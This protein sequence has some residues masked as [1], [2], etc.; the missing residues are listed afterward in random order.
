MK[1]RMTVIAVM[2][3][4]ISLSWTWPCFAAEKT[5]NLVFTVKDMVNP[6]WKGG[7]IG[8]QKAV[9][10]YK[11]VNITY[12]TPTKP[13]NIAEQTSQMEDII[14]RRPDAIVFVPVD[15]VAL[16]PTVEKMNKAGIPVFNYCNEVVGAKKQLY[17]GVDDEKLAY[18][19]AKFA[20]NAIGNKGKVVIID[21][22]PGAI[23][24]QNR[25]TGFMKAV[26]EFPQIELLDAQPANYNQLLA[27]QVME[28]LLQKFP[29]IDLVLTAGDSSAMGVL[30]A[31]DSAGRLK[32][33]KI[34]GVDA[35]VDASNAILQGRLFATAE[36]SIHNQAYLATKAAIKFL[37]GEKV[38]KR[39]ILPDTIVVQKNAK[40]WT[41]PFEEWESPNYD[42][43]VKTNAQW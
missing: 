38:P 27:M 18:T 36:Y 20:F 31:V 19:M 5:L 2:V 33:I 1:T 6:A 8:A 35:N 23:T 10:E 37:K 42:E 25:H 32:E 29:K 3:M 4:L 39:L 9:K 28:N 7:W 40:K 30:E 34:T 16:V 12:S 14:L 26:K 21:G 17:V 41:R 13:G 15:Y 22:T 24:A 11:G 43:I